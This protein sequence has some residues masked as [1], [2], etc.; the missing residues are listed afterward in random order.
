MK[1]VK[2]TT[3]ILAIFLVTLTAFAGVYVQT[4]NRMENK[5]KDYE[6]GRE[7]KGGRVIELKVSE[8]T[9][10][11]ETTES[12]D[13][14]STDTTKTE[15]NDP[16]K[17]TA[18]NY[19]IV[20]KTI[21]K[22]LEKLGAQDY[23][24]S[25]DK[26]TGLIRVEIAENE[27]TDNYAYYLTASGKVEIKEKDTENVLIDDSMIKS[28][29]YTYQGNASNKY[30]VSLE[31]NL[32][33]E[34]QAKLKELSNEYALL[35]TEV[36]EINSKQNTTTNETTEETTDDTNTE[37]TT[38]EE[39][40]ENNTEEATKKVAELSIAGTEYDIS[41]IE[42]NKIT[43]KIGSETSNSTTLNNNLS[44]AAEYAM[45][46]DSGKYPVVYEIK[47]NRY[48][49][50]DIT[51]NEIMYFFIAVLVVILVV[52]ILFTVKYK[53]NG[54]L[55]S[56]SAIGL[57]SLLSLVLRYT[58]V[59]ISIEGIGAIIFMIAVDLYIT[60]SILNKIQKTQLIN[61]SVNNTL[62]D[63]CIKLIPIIIMA[64]V[65][66]FSGWLNLSSFGMIVFWGV[67]LI[68][69]YNVIVTKALLN[70]KD[71]K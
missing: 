60:Y 7:L 52:F 30:Q 47:N 67:I 63:S 12:S 4:Q 29:H 44:R 19:E 37:N 22:R 45:L 54:L 3:I 58:N 69:L 41:K 26:E 36:S 11:T 51:N 24:V 9:D 68:E 31:L 50:S 65:F 27:S 5:V 40:T 20:K 10:D 38:V 15:K 62:K 32:T 48:I 6:L 16:E 61:E 14:E 34:G 8:T 35:S 25:L 59:S 2:I 49:Y 1:K 43:V 13:T 70:L 18:E 39:S 55:C 23:T 66:C 21:E 64:L 53:L 56:I 42:K 71:N 33:K 57:I 28:A 46:I 17:L